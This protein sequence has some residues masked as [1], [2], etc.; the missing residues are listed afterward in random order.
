MMPG[1]LTPSWA[2]EV[3]VPTDLSCFS[4]GWESSRCPMGG[5]AWGLQKWGAKVPEELLPWSLKLDLATCLCS[6]LHLLCSGQDG[7]PHCLLPLWATWASAACVCPGIPLRPSPVT[8]FP[9][10]DSSSAPKPEP[11]SQSSARV[12]HSL[13][14][15][16]GS[17]QGDKVCL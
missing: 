3:R 9:S 11:V 14:L 1:C 6:Q 8:C 16:P 4:Q 12:L 13:L 7:L 15:H 10:L 17:V 2:C 5:M